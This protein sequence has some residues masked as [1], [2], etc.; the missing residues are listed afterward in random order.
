MGEDWVGYVVLELWAE[1]RRQVPGTEMLRIGCTG[2]P[3]LTTRL[4]DGG[5]LARLYDEQ[6]VRGLGELFGRVRA[7]GDAEGE[8]S[9]LAD[10]ADAIAMVA[11]DGWTCRVC[12][13]DAGDISLA[14]TGEVRVISFAGELTRR[15]TEVAPLWD[16]IVAGSAAAVYAVDP[17]LAPWWCPECSASYCGEHWASGRC[18][19]GH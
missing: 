4:R 8:L 7:L 15:V 16:A 18:P 11:E 9:A 5:Y 2:E 6:P 10:R 1:L 19:Q 12:F 3:E 14:E 13:A 17:E